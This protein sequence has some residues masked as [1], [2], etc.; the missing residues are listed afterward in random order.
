MWV[1]SYFYN[2]NRVK[3]Y[4]VLQ[5]SCLLAPGCLPLRLPPPP[6]RRETKP[7][8]NWIPRHYVST[9]K[10]NC[11]IASH[12]ASQSA[13]ENQRSSHWQPLTLIEWMITWP[14][15]P[16]RNETMAPVVWES[17]HNLNRKKTRK[18]DFNRVFLLVVEFC[19]LRETTSKSWSCFRFRS[20]SRRQFRTEGDVEKHW[21]LL[22][23]T[24]ILQL[25]IA[26]SVE[27]RALL[28]QNLEKVPSTPGFVPPQTMG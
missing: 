6:R 1:V 24:L 2:W 4:V 21:F 9:V 23:S 26:S 28:G 7:G 19:R 25:H 22:E 15:K 8:K 16:F 13:I 17:N 5:M 20:L 12:T 11:R 10:A 3:G 14:G 27:S 18:S